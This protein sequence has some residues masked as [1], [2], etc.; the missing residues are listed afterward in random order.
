MTT[1]R[2]PIPIGTKSGSWT[3]IGPGFKSGTSPQIRIPVRCDCGNELSIMKHSFR[4]DKKNKQC[5]E[6]GR[7]ASG[8]KHR[9]GHGQIS[10]KHISSIRLTAKKRGILFEVSP[11]EMWAQ[12]L[13]QNGKCAL[14]GIDLVLKYDNTLRNNTASL[15]RIDSN[16]SYTVDNIQWVHK[17]INTMKWDMT[18]NE[19]LYFCEKIV[20]F[21]ATFVGG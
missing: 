17:K 13:K 15:D 1:E 7:K 6:C 2:K 8:N 14:S 5:V 9:N 4:Y 3:C 16:K 10:G 19:L 12:F 18:K 11:Q 20:E 21:N